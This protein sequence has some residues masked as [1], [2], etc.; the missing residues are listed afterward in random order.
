MF[1][2]MLMLTP[3]LAFEVQLEGAPEENVDI[4]AAP[5]FTLNGHAL[6]SISVGDVNGDQDLTFS[7]DNVNSGNVY[8]TG[9]MH[10][11]AEDWD[12]WFDVDSIYVIKS[13][14]DSIVVTFN[15]KLKKDSEQECIIS[16]NLAMTGEISSEGYMVL[17]REDFTFDGIMKGT[18][19]AWAD[20]KKK[21]LII[22]QPYPG[23]E[24]S[25]DR[26]VVVSGK[27]YETFTQTFTDIVVEDQGVWSASYSVNELAKGKLS[28]TGTIVVGPQA[29]PVDEIAQKVSGTKKNGIFSWTTTSTSK[30]DS[31]VKVTIKQTAS[32]LDLVNDGKN[33]VSAA[34]QTRTF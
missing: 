8:T 34:A 3:C 9:S 4:I 21:L 30:T 2:T 17:V 12:A 23:S 13:Y 15:H 28:G 6:S 33:S 19:K 1:G 25:A 16:G 10:L 26:I 27:R 14:G 11:T 7:M 24:V 22:N 5:I 31:K 18:I 20:L 29:D 32:D